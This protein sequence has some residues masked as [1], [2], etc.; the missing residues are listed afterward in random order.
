MMKDGC[1]WWV[2]RF[3]NMQKYFDAYRIDHVL[4]FFR[5][6]EIPV[7]SVHGLLGQF[8]PA[9]ALTTE[10][11]EAY[12][13]KMQSDLFTKPYI[14][15]EILEDIFGPRAAYIRDNFVKPYRDGR[16]LMREEYDTQRKI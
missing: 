3:R 10:E 13:I 14:T 15:K 4:G 8:Q 2:R 1:Q 6:W 12:G 9:L 16:Y 5:I 11:I 7:D